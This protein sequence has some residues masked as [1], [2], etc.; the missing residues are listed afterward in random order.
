MTPVRIRSFRETP[1]HPTPSFQCR[2]VIPRFSELK[3]AHAGTP[4][5]HQ[6]S[7]LG[8]FFQ[9]LP[10]LIN[11]IQRPKSVKSSK[12][13]TMAISL[14]SVITQAEDEALDNE[15][16]DNEPT[17]LRDN[18]CASNKTP[19]AI[20]QFNFFLVDYCN[21]KNFPIKVNSIDHIPYEGLEGV[22]AF[23]R[24]GEDY[25]QMFWSD[26]IGA[27]FNYLAFDAYKFL[28]KSKGL[29]SYD[30]ATSY[31]SAVKKHLERVRFR[32]KPELRVLAESQWREL[33]N[34]LLSKHANRARKN[35][36]KLTN[37][38]IG[39]TSDD[40]KAMAKACF[41]LATAE[42]AEFHA[43]NIV[44]FHLIGR[45]REVSVLT[46]DDL[47][48]VQ[49]DEEIEDHY[50]IS[51]CLQRD[52]GKGSTPDSPQELTLYPHQRSI[53]HDPYFALGYSLLVGGCN[54]SHIF[55]RFFRE[56]NVFDKNDKTESRVSTLWSNCLSKLYKAFNELSE[57][58]TKKL[59][60]YHSRK[61]A[62]QHLA[63]SSAGGLA[64]VFRTGWQ[65]RGL[66]TLF[67]YVVSSKPLTNKA[68]KALAGWRPDALALPPKLARIR[69]HPEL[70]DDFV[71]ALFSQDI[72]MHW[73][74]K[75][76]YTLTASILRFYPD[77]LAIIEQN[78]R[79]SCETP[80]SQHP[81]VHAVQKAARLAKV[82][83]DTFNNWVAEIRYSFASA[84]FLEVPINSLPPDLAQF[85][86][87]DSRS[88]FERY[89]NLVSCYNSLHMQ[90]MALEDDVA[91]LRQD[92]ANLVR[93]QSRQESIISSQ[94]ELLA[95]IAS[96]LEI[97]FD[98]QTP[99]TTPEPTSD[100][101]PF[102][103]SYK[104]FRE[105]S[106][107]L[108]QVFVKFFVD[109]C[110]QGWEAEK[111]SDSFK[112]MLPSERKLLSANYKRLKKTIKIMLFFCDRFPP[113]QPD[114]PSKLSAWYRDLTDLSKQALTQLTE[115]IPDAPKPLT[116]TFVAKASSVNQ[117]ETKGHPN[118][119]YFPSD[120][121]RSILFHF[122]AM[123][124][125][126]D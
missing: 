22:V 59:T 54:R 19:A 58:L 21:R 6:I 73:P 112:A 87:V 66:H 47:S 108:D 64:Q 51:V 36:K 55:P 77:F 75:I 8:F 79:H 76:R 44:S 9:P 56:A 115:A 50:A 95:K 121:P 125:D 70:V 57:T 103:V 40:R 80:H 94:N 114:D 102:S 31:A 46:P 90:K 62:S 85:R 10:S 124:R 74:R 34:C 14:L 24:D 84:N 65:L 91:R 45:G 89:N 7:F 20:K 72:E 28:N 39:S 1:F 41:W 15:A 60:C 29:L 96:V 2:T 119:K 123:I 120:T 97:K 4:L 116:Q 38:K 52:K 98:K 3:L 93:S 81:F 42:A 27:F 13:S 104:D 18:N 100:V 11:S 30:S 35:G 109:N 32:H 78:P 82:S 107:C 113:A 12:I 105:I 106:N 33:R 117:W 122:D 37:P 26:L 63:E 126:D 71:T 43:L 92:V 111:R 69:S 49:V 53:E 16:L 86:Q 101:K 5:P 23:N 110:V 83:D 118:V 88:L 25:I 17:D 68:G 99:S 67:D 61:G 48:P